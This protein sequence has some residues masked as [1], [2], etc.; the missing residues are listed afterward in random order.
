[1]PSLKTSPTRHIAYGGNRGK[2]TLLNAL[3]FLFF[4]KSAEFR[5]YHPTFITP[6]AIEFLEY[7]KHIFETLPKKKKKHFRKLPT[8]RIKSSNALFGQFLS[9][10]APAPSGTT[11]RT[12]VRIYTI[13][14]HALSSFLCVKAFM[15]TSFQKT[16]TETLDKILAEPALADSLVAPLQ[17][18]IHNIT[19]GLEGNT[20]MIHKRAE[21]F[22]T[23][24]VRTKLGR[25]AILDIECDHVLET[26][27]SR[28]TEGVQKL[29]GEQATYD[30]YIVLPITYS[31]GTTGCEG[32]METCVETACKY[33]TL[34]SSFVKAY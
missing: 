11:C 30:W 23:D 34:I 25:T 21:G 33:P 17:W 20:A 16:A 2:E 22:I 5:K 29:L 3:D 9:F 19:P 1:M 26:L 13:V 4:I 31:L 28:I 18:F 15:N 12:V 27:G 6:S 10:L 7:A 14:M 24:I 32:Y 8:L